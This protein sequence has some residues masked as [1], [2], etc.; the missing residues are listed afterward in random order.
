MLVLRSLNYGVSDAA[1]AHVAAKISVASGLAAIGALATYGTQSSHAV[2]SDR[3]QLLANAIVQ[4]A[5]WVQLLL[6]LICGV[7]DAVS[8][9]VAE[10]LVAHPLWR[11]LGCL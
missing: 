7:S 1:S 6:A 8:A 5:A 10:K 9:H 3:A 2:I 11:Q 4:R